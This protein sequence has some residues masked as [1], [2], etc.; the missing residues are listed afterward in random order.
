MSSIKKQITI[1]DKNAHNII[2]SI[3]T[4]TGETEFYIPSNRSIITT[5]EQLFVLYDALT[6][7]LNKMQRGE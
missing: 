7:V 4:K 2:I 5:K 6:I 3:N 1:T